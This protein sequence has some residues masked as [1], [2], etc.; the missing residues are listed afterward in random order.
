MLRHV[1]SKRGDWP[2]QSFPWNHRIN[3]ESKVVKLLR[4]TFY[5]MYRSVPRRKMAT[6]IAIQRLPFYLRESEKR[7]NAHPFYRSCHKAIGAHFLFTIT[8][9]YNATLEVGTFSK[10]A[11]SSDVSSSPVDRARSWRL[12]T[13][14][15]AHSK[16]EK[17]DGEFIQNVLIRTIFLYGDTTGVQGAS[18]FERK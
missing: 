13:T 7:H 14:N 11:V 8:G 4:N 6:C 2:L 5:G 16:K 3:W 17:N 15:L 12:A 1:P 9:A 10:L 18:R